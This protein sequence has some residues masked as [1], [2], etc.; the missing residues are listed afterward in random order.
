MKTPGLLLVLTAA[1]LGAAETKAPPPADKPP[2]WLKTYTLSPYKQIW[3]TQV[4]VRKLDK[5]FPKLVDAVKK[6][7]GKPTQALENFAASPKTRQVSFEISKA[8]AAKALKMIK[9]I[10][11]AGEPRIGLPPETVPIDE[12]RGKLAVLTKAQTD[13]AA[14]LAMM[15]AVAEATQEL[16][17]RLRVVEAAQSRTESEVLWNITVEERP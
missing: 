15:P 8:G 13:H 9:K 14:E 16:I 17:E 10:G 5:D 6:N 3:S 7:G 12:V 1:S 11:K 4:T 2:V